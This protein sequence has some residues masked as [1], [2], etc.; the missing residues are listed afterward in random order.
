MM[1]ILRTIQ[2]FVVGVKCIREISRKLCF[3][4]SLSFYRVQVQ[5]ST[6]DILVSSCTD[7]VT[8]KDVALIINREGGFKP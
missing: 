7:H 5:Y 2:S 6:V 8:S 4:M 1:L 3:R